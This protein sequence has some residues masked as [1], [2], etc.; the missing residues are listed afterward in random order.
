MPRTSICQAGTFLHFTLSLAV[1]ILNFHRRQFVGLLLHHVHDNH[2]PAETCNL[3]L[4]GQDLIDEARTVLVGNR[5]ALQR[6]Q[7]PLN[8]DSSDS[9]F[10]NFNQ[11]TL[12]FFL[13][14]SIW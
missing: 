6:M 5:N 9:A 11:V 10:A 7:A 12:C 4:F 3:I 8:G 14:N 2:G 13:C 1:G